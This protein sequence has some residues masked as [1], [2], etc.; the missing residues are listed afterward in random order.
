MNVKKLEPSL[1][2]SRS[3]NTYRLEDKSNNEAPT[4]PSVNLPKPAESPTT[5]TSKKSANGI[6][7]RIDAV[8]EGMRQQGLIKNESP[9]SQ[10]D[11][12]TAS[13]LASEIEVQSSGAMAEDAEQEFAP[14]PV[15]DWLLMIEKLIARKDYAEAARQLQKFKQVHPKVNV[16]DLDAKIP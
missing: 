1:E 14:I 16:E 9:Q 13:D 15:E 7:N 8:D 11:T 4:T 3:S 12:N 6:D 10:Q 5:S 2:K